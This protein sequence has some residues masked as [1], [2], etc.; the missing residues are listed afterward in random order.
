[1]FVCADPH[2]YETT[3]TTVTFTAGVQDLPMGSAPVRPTLRLVDSVDPVVVYRDSAGNE[4][5][6]IEITGTL[7]GELIA[8]RT[9]ISLDGANSADALTGGDFLHFEPQHGSAAAPATIELLSGSAVTAQVIY[10]R[11]W[12]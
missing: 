5:G 12:S 3:E 1:V 9:G 2:T 11:A 6:R 7:T 4:Q 10:R 8:D